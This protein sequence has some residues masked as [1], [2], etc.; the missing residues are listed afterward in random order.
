MMTKHTIFHDDK[1][2]YMSWWQ[3]ALYVMMT[4]R[5]MSWWQNAL[6]VMM[7]KRT[8]CHDDKTHYMSRW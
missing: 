3:N 4:K 5:T 8:I 2:H 6:Y 7:T 1:T